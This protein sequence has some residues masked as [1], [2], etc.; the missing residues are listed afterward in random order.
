MNPNR[1]KKTKRKIDGLRQMPLFTEPYVSALTTQPPIFEV[2][3]GGVVGGDNAVRGKFRL[4]FD[5]RC[6]L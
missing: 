1:K 4:P 5:S 2:S 6:R 3:A